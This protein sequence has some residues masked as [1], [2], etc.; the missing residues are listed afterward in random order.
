M[1]LIFGLGVLS[2]QAGERVLTINEGNGNAAWFVS[3][4]TL[5][6]NGFDLNSLGV[7]TPAVIDR[8]SIQVDLPIAGATST[9]VIYEDANGGS[10][11]DATLIA[12]S[13]VQITQAGTFTVTL[14]NPATITQRAVWVGF[15]LP[16][17]FQFLADTSGPSVLTYWAWT[18]G[19][20]FDLNNLGS[21]QVLGPA[22]G[23]APVNLNINGKARITAEITE[24]TTVAATTPQ[25][26]QQTNANL[27]V[28][29]PYGLCGSV[30]YD[31]ADEFVS[32]ENRIDIIC[33]EV[34]HYEGP[35]SA[36]PGHIRRGPLYD[37]QVFK[38]NGVVVQNRFEYSVT[39]CFRP[40]AEDIDRAVIGNA[41]GIPR[42]WR[43]LTTQ[44]F[45]DLVCAEVWHG[46]N[47]ALF[48]RTN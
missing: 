43:L 18:P 23:T 28:L 44:R 15:Y 34:A 30:L 45:G 27:S 5:V 35:V 41:W 19:T 9:V 2:A 46:G 24:G 17:N 25:P 10:P 33:R 13:Q 37:L 12:Q 20:T 7:S 29:Q 31:T 3:N 26:Q 48:V 36:P 47:L 22:N 38:E 21:A 1:L 4:Q 32:Y 6:I 42:T 39:H 14:P 40:A 16:P 8:V 11:V